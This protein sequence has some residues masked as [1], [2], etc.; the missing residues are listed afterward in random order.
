MRRQQFYYDLPE[1]L[2]AQYPVNP[3][4]TAKLLAYNKFSQELQHHDSIL[5]LLDYLQ[6]GDL[7][8]CNNTKVLPARVFGQKTTGGQV[9]ILFERLLSSNKMLC[10][11]RASKA[12]KPLTEIL[13]ND[14]WRLKVLGR[15][16]DLFEV[17]VN[18]QVIDMLHE[19]GH[20][21]LPPYIE[22]K[23]EESD[24]EKYQTVFA[25]HLGSIAAPT[26]GL[27]FDDVVLSQLKE[28]Q[29][30]LDEITLHV[31]AGTFKPVRADLIQ[32]HVMHHE[33]YE[34]SPELVNK[35]KQTKANGGR[36]IAIGTTA[37]RALES[38]AQAG[39]KPSSGLTNLFIT[40][41]YEFKVIDGLMTNFHLPESTLLMLV[42]ALIG[43][44]KM[45]EIYQQAVIK[46]YRFF[47]YG[48]ACLFL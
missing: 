41:G 43:Y 42:S 32:D 18:G 46:E 16:D 27:H 3:R 15:Q 19:V 21:P 39:L 22:R 28:K 7:L 11:V 12:P 23:D 37:L 9:E 48:D 1:R 34:V 20:M 29:I 30:Q 35:I 40:P 25:K 6:A 14:S 47:S 17:E 31:G 38:A 26:A 44:E 10:H 33:W 45:M 24:K 13:I 36:V 4:H 2:I 5:N 8:V